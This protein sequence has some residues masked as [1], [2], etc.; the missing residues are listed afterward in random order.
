MSHESTVYIIHENAAYMI[1]ENTVFMIHENVI[2]DSLNF[3]IYSLSTTIQLILCVWSNQLWCFHFKLMDLYPDVHI[4]IHSNASKYASCVR[5]FITYTHI[6]HI[7]MKYHISSSFLSNLLLLV[8]FL[9]IYTNNNNT[10]FSLYRLLPVPFIY[11]CVYNNNTTSY[12]P[13]YRLPSGPFLR[14]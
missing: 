4:T 10:I 6:T 14:I 5:T 13:F 3:I 9:R 1:H 12:F 7:H 8:P 2:C 11:V